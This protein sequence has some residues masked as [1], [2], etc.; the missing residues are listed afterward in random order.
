MLVVAL[1]TNGDYQSDS[2][3]TF[4]LRTDFA[5]RSAAAVVT[6]TSKAGREFVIV[7]S[8]GY[9]NESN[10]NDPNNEPS[11]GVILLVSDPTTGGFDNSRTR[12]LVTVG[13]NRLYNA[14]AL[15]L[16]PN[17]DLLIADFHSDELRIVRDTDSDGIPD[18]L[19]ATPYYST[20]FPTMSRSMLLSIRA[21]S[22]SRIPPAT[23]WSCSRSMMTMPTASPIATKFASKAFRSTT[24]FFCMD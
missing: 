1:D 5:L 21:A 22:C 19:S 10:P 3:T 20:G 15:A 12:T 18:T 7:S 8:S 4:N 13:D 6:G 14:N 2:S 24:I 9:F 11:P 23:T 17:N 16:L